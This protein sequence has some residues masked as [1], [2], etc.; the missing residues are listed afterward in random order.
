MKNIFTC[1]TNINVFFL[2]TGRVMHAFKKH[3]AVKSYVGLAIFFSLTALTTNS[4]AQTFIHPG[5]LHTQADLDRMKAKVAAG[6]HP[7]IDDWNKLITDG[8]AQNTYTPA[9]RAN[10]GGS[11]QRADADAHAAYLNALRWYISGDT[12]YAACAVRICNAWSAAVNQVPTGTDIPGLSGIP[13][14]DFAMAAEVLRIYPG[15]DTASFN[16]FKNMMVTYFYPVCHDFLTNHNGACISAYWSNWDICNTGAILT[17]GVL[18]DDTTKFNEAVNYF[19]YG[20][21]MGSIMNAVYY[22]HPNGLGQ[23]QESGRDQEHAQLAVGMMASICQVAWNQGL[24]LFSYDNNRLLAG[25]EYVARTNLSQPVPYVAYNNCQNAN[26]KW[27]SINGMGR[28]DDRPVYELIY[29]HYVVQQGL[30]APNVQA[31]A[32]LIRPEHGSADHFGYGTLAFTL[33]AAASA[34]PPAPVAAAPTGLSATAGVSRITLNWTVPS[35]NTVQGYNVLR[36]TT[37]GGPYTTI[38][39]WSDNTYP[40]YTDASVTNGTIYYY[41]LSA[42]NQSGT[43]S[44]SSEVSATPL[45]TSSSLPSGWA[46]QDIG[47]VGLT[48]SAA[49]ANVSNN[50]FAVSGAGAGIG[51]TS[52]ALGYT[53]GSVSG[54]VTITA[55]ILSLGGTLGKTGIMMRE[56]LSPDAKALIMKLGDVGWRQAGFGTRAS[57]GGSMTWVGGNDYT[58]QP[59][60]FRLQRSGSTF[61]AFESSDGITWFEVGTST[62]AMSDTFYV[63]LAVTSGNTG[64]LNTSTFDNIT[65]TGGGNAPASPSGL[66]ASAGNTQ[67]A[68]SWNTLN[69][70]SGYNIKRSTV[71]GGAYTTIAT[72]ITATS[73]TD[74]SVANG[75][76]Y[77]YVISAANLA[78]EGQNSFEVTATPVLTLPQAPS[79]LNAVVISANEIDLSWGNSISATGYIIKR[80]STSCGNYTTLDTV[81]AN[82]Y[83]DTTIQSSVNYYYTVSALNA[84][85]EGPASLPVNALAGNKLAGTLIGTTGSWNNNSATTKAAAVDG[86]LNTFF[87]AA[88]GSGAWVGIDLG[89][90]NN[91]GVTQ[92]RYAPRSGYESRMVSGVF[93]GANNADFSDAVTLFTVKTQPS[94]GVLTKQNITDSVPFRYLRYLSPTNGYCNIAEV[95]F[96]GQPAKLPVIT[97]AGTAN[98]S[99]DSLFSYT[100]AASNNA[101]SFKATGLPDSLSISSCS[102]VISGKL[103]ST[104]VFPVIISA[105][106]AFG[107]AT[108]TLLLTVKRNQSIIFNAIANKK[109][110]DIDFDAAATSSS[111]LPATYTSSDTTIA[112]IVNGRIHLVDTGACV[113]TASQKGDST[114]WPA[115][116]I[117]RTLIVN[118]LNVQVQYKNGDSNYPANNTIKPYLKIVNADSVNITYKELTVRY[119][120]TAENY[121]GINSW[122]DYTQ[123]GNNKVKMKYVQ[124]AQPLNNAFGYIEYS[125]DSTTGNLSAGANSGEIQS[126]FS[127]TDWSNFNELND[128]SYL[129]A[130]SYTTNN[131][132][133]VYRN[134]VLVWG[135]EPAAVTPVVTL[136]AYYQNKNTTATTNAIQ[137]YFKINNEGNVPVAYKDIT[138]RYWFTEDGT[139]SLNYWIDYAKVGI[140]KVAGQFIKPSPV[141]DSADTYF[142]LKIDSTV[143]IF[144]PLSGTGDIQYRFSKSDWSNFNELND[145]SYKPAAPYAENNRIT[146]Y[147]KGQ[148]VYGTEPVTGANAR[149]VTTH[150][151]SVNVEDRIVTIGQVTNI[152]PNPVTG[153]RF[154]INTNNKTISAD[155]LNIK[156]YDLYGRIV[157]N[158]NIPYAKGA[159]TEVRF[160]KALPAGAYM[161]QVNDNAA[162][163]LIISR[164]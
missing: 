119:W 35:G 84:L 111:S 57:S 22:V 96:W 70:A 95:E 13:I 8:Q 91:A 114:Y 39:S 15:W 75:T 30:S 121:T 90:G 81:A 38:A 98:G 12:T 112:T 133:T 127:N 109:M 36:S 149:T 73:Y 56:S 97:N 161:V 143:G 10:M 69:G 31:M 93:Q 9:A 74:T 123:I 156:V 61:T 29:N 124:S 89:A 68:L 14:F 52:D 63:G 77:Y 117:T 138:A 126:R 94:S 140:S 118:P 100:V 142:E 135:T 85:G 3:I 41:V 71:S 42:N 151:S 137:A 88:V 129:N 107:I 144:Y 130:T 1:K 153:N 147:Y 122:I 66:T 44:N 40:Q 25:A 164:Q 82:S 26:Q 60:W 6:A 11:R 113:I 139:A 37:S 159:A 128:Y 105:A 45:A 55:R 78:G 92:V 125:F 99:Y 80:A 152:Y 46:R 72:G 87:D 49:Y 53:Y 54:D 106:N 62:V 5:G 116:A 154:Y 28:L 141:R 51:G 150:H 160:D 59:A 157:L 19:K 20:A 67:V 155:K 136:K 86:N 131:H 23:W 148:L 120:F 64:A 146:I 83:R 104:G 18:C 101:S 110:G 65:I 58:W 48:G 43:S 50:T 32:Q 102:G 4:N 47:S 17:I 27:V 158:K 24:D 16:R 115:S 33:D 162:G 34:Y 2:Y 134:G 7:W 21:G 132:I 145:Y 103:K 76:S 163:K 108:D 79:G